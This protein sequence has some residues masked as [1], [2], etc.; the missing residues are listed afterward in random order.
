MLKLGCTLHILADTSLHKRRKYT[1]FPFVESDMEL[2][3]KIREDMNGEPSIVFTRKAIAEI[4][5]S[6]IQ[7][8]F[9]YL[10]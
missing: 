2:H 10:S 8:T 9:V 6:E 7:E 3:D 5:T 1:L 4:Q